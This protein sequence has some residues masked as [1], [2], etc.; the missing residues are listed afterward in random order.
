MWYLLYC[1]IALSSMLAVMFA[2]MRENF[3][4][5][6]YLFHKSKCYDCE[7]HIA[8][9]EGVDAVWKA[10]PTKLFSAESDGVSQAGDVSGG[11][12]GKTLKFY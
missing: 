1:I 5:D 7:Q 8:S 2:T 4:T 11:Y 9:T 12:L 10:Q 6:Q 3:V